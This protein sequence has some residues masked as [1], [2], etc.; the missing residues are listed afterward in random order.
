LRPKQS[1][2]KEHFLRIAY[3][4]LRSSSCEDRTEN[5]LALDINIYDQSCTETSINC[6]LSDLDDSNDTYD[7]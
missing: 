3:L 7:F 1:I 4:T 6:N 5:S 2:S